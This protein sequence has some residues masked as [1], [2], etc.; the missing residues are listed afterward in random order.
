MINLTMGWGKG[1]ASKGKSTLNL[2]KFDRT[3]YENHPSVEDYCG[4]ITPRFA[5]V[6]LKLPE[7]EGMYAKLII[8]GNGIQ[9]LVYNNAGE[10]TMFFCRELHPFPLAVFVAEHLEEPLDPAVLTRFGFERFR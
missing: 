9:V 6:N 2:R 7:Y 5:Q 10:E 1:T 4:E 3:D 8:D